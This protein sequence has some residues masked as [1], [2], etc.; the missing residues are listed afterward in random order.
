MTDGIKDPSSTAFD[1]SMKTAPVASTV[2]FLSD[3]ISEVSN[4]YSSV[5]QFGRKTNCYLQSSL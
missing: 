2:G 5:E 3:V 1:K 4:S